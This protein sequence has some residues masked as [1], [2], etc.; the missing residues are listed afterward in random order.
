MNLEKNTQPVEMSLV[1]KIVAAVQA[2]QQQVPAA[3]SL[4]ECEAAAQQLAQHLA[5]MTLSAQLAARQTASVSEK[6]LPCACGK[7]QYLQRQQARTVRT[8][9]GPVSYVRPYYYCRACGA[10]RVPL[11]EA[12]GQDARDVTAGVVRLVAEFSAHLSFG[13]TATLLEKA[14]PLVALS[15][16]QVETIAEAVGAQAAAAQLAAVVQASATAL[17]AAAP[18]YLRLVGAP[19]PAARTWIIEMDGIHAPLRDGTWQEVKCGLV[20]RHD[21]RI[22]LSK[23]RGVLLQKLRCAVRGGVAEFRAQLWAQ[24][25]AAGVRSTDQLVVLGDGAAW[26]DETV[27]E[28]FPR[29]RRIL[30]FF[31]VAEHLWEVAHAR[32]GEGAQA[33]KT[34][35]TAKLAQLKQGRWAAVCRALNQLRLSSVAAQKRD[36]TVG[37]LRRHSTQLA[38]DR[39]QAEGLPIGSGA[40]EGTCKYLV[41]SRCKQAG[42]RWSTAGLDALLALRCRVLNEQLDTLLPPP[43]LKLVWDSTTNL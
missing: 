33:A 32:F 14:H 2:W 35:M 5:Q 38:Y 12:L 30:D 29:A 10:A 42:M 17:A 41:A 3:A 34:W 23:D 15:A 39:Y 21:Q 27:A 22:E 20:Y 13:T 9:V 25:I 43:K 37:Y 1:S 11:D 24:L 18:P 36:E 19:A 26:I 7:R 16:R 8:L 4:A 28:L 6:S 31:H 40:I